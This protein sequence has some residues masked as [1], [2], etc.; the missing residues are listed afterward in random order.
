MVK[1]FINEKDEYNIN[2]CICKDETS[3]TCKKY[4]EK[5]EICPYAEE[6]NII[7]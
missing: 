3:S 4:D 7:I 1:I 2:S 5:C 6:N